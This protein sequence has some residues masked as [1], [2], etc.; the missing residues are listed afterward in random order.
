MPT[1]AQTCCPSGHGPL[2]YVDSTGVYYNAMT[3]TYIPVT[4]F[5]GTPAGPVLP[6]TGAYNKCILANGV[7]AIGPVYDPIACPCCPI[8]AIWRGDLNKCWYYLSTCVTCS[9][10][11]VDPIPC[12]TC[13][14]PT[15]PPP[16]LCESCNQTALP[17]PI[18]YNDTIKQ[19]IDCAT[20]ESPRE[21]EDTNLNSFTTPPLID[22]ITNFKLKE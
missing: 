7:T 9:A 20:D 19:C 15:P 4:N 8:N 5:L 1:P 12:I 6:V 16:P 21:S 10:N 13:V 17:I 14:C 2:A 18:T 3:N 22:P 11:Y